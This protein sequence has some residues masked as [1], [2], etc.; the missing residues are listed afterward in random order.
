M[1][2]SAMAPRSYQYS[3]HLGFMKSRVPGIDALSMVEVRIHDALCFGHDG[4]RSLDGLKRT[5]FGMWRLV[6]EGRRGPVRTICHR[7]PLK[8]HALAFFYPVKRVIPSIAGS[9]VS[10]IPGYIMISFSRPNQYSMKRLPRRW[11]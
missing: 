11:P 6:G 3:K 5:I 7:V 1:T 9:S 8:G 4:R 2:S 10:G